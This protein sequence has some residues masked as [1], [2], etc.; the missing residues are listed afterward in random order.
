V[1]SDLNWCGV[2]LYVKIGDYALKIA[3]PLFL[4]SH[5]FL[6]LGLSY[7]LTTTYLIY[8]PFLYIKGV[9]LDDSFDLLFILL[10]LIIKKL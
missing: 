2:Q 10:G 4:R 8:N 1:I 6:E 3:K 5:T 7:N 9:I